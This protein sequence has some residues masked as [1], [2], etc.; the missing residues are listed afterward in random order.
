VATSEAQLFKQRCAHLVETIGKDCFQLVDEIKTLDAVC[1]V[2]RSVFSVNRKKKTQQ[3]NNRHLI[4]QAS[5][6]QQMN[7]M[8]HYTSHPKNIAS[9]ATWRPQQGGTFMVTTCSKTVSVQLDHLPS[10]YES[11]AIEYLSITG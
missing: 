5:R 8:N 11:L 7:I 3:D 10:E 2:I 6:S 1:N 4:M 9:C